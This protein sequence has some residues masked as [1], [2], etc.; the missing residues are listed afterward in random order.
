MTLFAS[1]RSSARTLVWI[2]RAVGEI[3]LVSVRFLTSQ[4]NLIG[5]VNVRVPPS[6][7]DDGIHV[8][9]LDSQSYASGL[10]VCRS[11]V[12][13]SGVGANN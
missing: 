13:A 12:A 11:N 7:V 6:A 1:Q 10:S 4:S 8:P 3:R 5:V 9:F 2:F